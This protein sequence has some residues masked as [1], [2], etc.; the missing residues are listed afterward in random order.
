MR[1]FVRPMLGSAARVIAVASLS[2]AAAMPAEPVADA[3]SQPA[4]DL[5][6][7]AFA[8]R[9][10]VDVSSVIELV[11]RSRTGQERRRTLQAM[12]KVIDDRVHSIGRLVEA[13]SWVHCFW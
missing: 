4:L 8:N 2:F 9:Y 6:N 10:D 12:S 1:E 11:V 7:R 13:Y 3:T 5:L